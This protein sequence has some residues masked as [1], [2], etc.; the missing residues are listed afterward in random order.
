MRFGTDR[1]QLFI[2]DAS[3]F[4]ICHVGHVDIPHGISQGIH[5]R[6]AEARSDP[7]YPRVFPQFS[8]FP[9]PTVRS[10]SPRAAWSRA[11][12]ERYRLAAEYTALGKPAPRR[13]VQLLWP[14]YA[15]R[16]RICSLLPVADHPAES[17]I[18]LQTTTSPSR[19]ELGKQRVDFIMNI[20]DCPAAA[21]PKRARTSFSLSDPFVVR[22]LADIENVPQTAQQW[23]LQ[24][25]SA[26]INM[27][28]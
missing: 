7:E 20:T 9:P 11:S 12:V 3:N 10:C 18:C 2:G 25:G 5:G 23:P 14:I 27:Y 15:P 24:S 19:F 21:T 13:F 17:K 6:S 8:Q 28:V 1:P 26:Y 4:E 16:T 22:E